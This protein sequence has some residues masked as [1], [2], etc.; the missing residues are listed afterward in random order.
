MRIGAERDTRRAAGAD[1]HLSGICLWRPCLL[2]RQTLD[3][4][5]DT[6]APTPVTPLRPDALTPL[7]RYAVTPLRRYAVTPLRHYAVTPMHSIL[8]SALILWRPC[9]LPRQ[10]LDI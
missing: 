7:C 10:T 8:D 9:V 5:V 6:Y 4:L 3:I 2:P 1:N